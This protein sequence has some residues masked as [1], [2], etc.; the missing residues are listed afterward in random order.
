MF[1]RQKN[2]RN[3]LFQ[4]PNESKPVFGKEQQIYFKQGVKRKVGNRQVLYSSKKIGGLK[5]E[6]LNIASLNL[7]FL[8]YTLFIG[9]SF[10]YNTI[11]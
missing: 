10:M 11:I 6:K 9:F 5:M 1:D 7:Q 3:S 4:K 8:Q 2:Q